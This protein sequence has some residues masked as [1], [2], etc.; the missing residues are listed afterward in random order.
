MASI[1]ND[2]GTLGDCIFN[3]H[4]AA[5]DTW[6]RST[7]QSIFLRASGTANQQASISSMNAD[8]FTLSWSKAGSPTGTANIL[9]TA[10]R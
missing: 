2:D 6:S 4:A 5:A 9:A 8:G 7:S 1:G 3:D 10:S